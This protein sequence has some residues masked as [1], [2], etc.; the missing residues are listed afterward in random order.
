PASAKPIASASAQPIAS[1]SGQPMPA[2]AAAP[3]A[4]A[5]PL[6]PEAPVAAPVEAALSKE[7]QGSLV[8]QTLERPLRP[9]EVSLDELERAFRETKTERDTAGTLVPQ[10]LERPLRPGEVSL[11]E[12]ERAFRST[13]TEVKP[14]H[15]AKAAARAP[16]AEP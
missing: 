13:A 11:D 12:L 6:V 2:G 5:P 9:G 1:G 15:A 3:V 14:A 10:I 4:E 8:D 7:T 16:A